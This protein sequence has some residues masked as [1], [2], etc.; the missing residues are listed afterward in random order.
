MLRRLVLAVLLCLAAPGAAQP[1]PAPATVRVALETE[2]GRHRARARD[3]ARAGHR[4]AI[5]CAMSTRAGSTA[6]NFYRAMH[7]AARTR[8]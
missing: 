5:S 1:A 3:G 7:G 6:P 4:R 8:A 2:R